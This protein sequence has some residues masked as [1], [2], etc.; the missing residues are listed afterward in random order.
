MMKKALA[1]AALGAPFMAFAEGETY[2]NTVTVSGLWNYL[3]TNFGSIV[4]ETFDKLATPIGIVISVTFVM[5]IFFLSVGLIRRGLSGRF[6][7]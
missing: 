7:G 6:R 4:N 5:A 2:S 3:S 1:L